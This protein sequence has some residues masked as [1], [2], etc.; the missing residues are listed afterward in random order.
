MS[1][2]KFVIDVLAFDHTN[3]SSHTVTMDSTDYAQCIS[4]L[5]KYA[6]HYMDLRLKKH[7]GIRDVEDIFVVINSG[8]NKTPYLV[9]QSE[10][11]GG[12]NDD[13]K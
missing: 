7:K 1:S 10:K 11:K 8:D 2:R 3:I 12:K 5:L 9:V 4:D 6:S 13:P